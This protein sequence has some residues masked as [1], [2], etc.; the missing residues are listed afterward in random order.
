[1]VDSNREAEQRLVE[2]QILAQ[3]SSSRNRTLSVRVRLENPAE[4]SIV[5]FLVMGADPILVFRQEDY[6]LMMHWEHKMDPEA[7][8]PVPLKGPQ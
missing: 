3:T 4:E 7:E 2:Y 5:R 6:D 8:E 1:M